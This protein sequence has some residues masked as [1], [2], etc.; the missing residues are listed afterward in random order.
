MEKSELVEEIKQG[1]KC[2]EHSLTVTSK[3]S[4]VIEVL[5]NVLDRINEIY[6]ILIDLVI[7]ELKQKGVLSPIDYDLSLEV[8]KKD[9][10]DLKNYIV[11]FEDI[12]YINELEHVRYK[13]F[14]IHFGFK[15]TYFKDE[16]IIDSYFVSKVFNTL[17]EMIKKV[18]SIVGIE[19][20]EQI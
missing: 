10:P 14:T 12:K 2:I 9:M 5:K 7:E 8:I 1:I 15:V 4:P 18:E 16:L 11:Y 20:T 17:L 19:V 3:I 6:T 13:E